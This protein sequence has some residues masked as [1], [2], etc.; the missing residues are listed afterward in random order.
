M[1]RSLILIALVVL[2]LGGLFFALRPTPQEAG[3]Q[4]REVDLEVRGDAM[5]PEEVVLGEGDAVTLRVVA[6][7]PMQLHLHG[8]DLEGKVSP[9]E[10]AE[11]SF[12]A[13]L[14]GRFEIE[15]E[16]THTELGTLVVEPR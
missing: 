14:T 2:G 1:S 5:T 4:E 15:E 13:N 8:Y 16:Q 3:P 9:D 12:D 11:L 10:P 6:D 7:R